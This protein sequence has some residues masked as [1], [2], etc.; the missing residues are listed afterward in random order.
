MI[1]GTGTD[2]LDVSRMER[3]LEEKDGLADKLFTPAEI[4]YCRSMRHPAQHFA[5]RFCAKEAFFK[6][7]GTGYRGGL[8]WHEVEVRR[9]V[10][11][12]PELHL[13]GKALEAAQN[14]GAQHL[15][16]SLSHTRQLALAMV[17]LES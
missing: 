5:A 1:L 13:T 16:L 17:I 12:R 10:L 6:A 9:N 11:G 15:H 2:L 8:A 14:L 3:D 7:L 4:G